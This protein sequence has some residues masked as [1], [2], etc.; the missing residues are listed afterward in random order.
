[1]PIYEYV[2]Q[3]CRHKFSVLV[4][5]PGESRATSCP[6]CRCDQTSRVFSTFSVRST[7]DKEVY[8]SILEDPKLTKGM[9]DND[10]KALAEWNRRMSGGIDQETPPEYQDMVERM[11]K[12]EMPS[13][14]A[15]KSMKVED[16]DSPPEKGGGEDA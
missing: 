16:T 12:G 9:M 7:T 8:E 11:E 14:E 5:T 1:M 2:C 3:K 4:R 10:P 6:K 13:P 15:I